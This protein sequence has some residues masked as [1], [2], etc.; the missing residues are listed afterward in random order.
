MGEEMGQRGQRLLTVTGN[1]G[2]LGDKCSLT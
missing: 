2:D 1:Y